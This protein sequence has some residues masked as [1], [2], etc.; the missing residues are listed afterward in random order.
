MTP[1]PEIIRKF[2]AVSSDYYTSSR[3]EMLPFIPQT[4]KRLLDLGCNKGAFGYLIKLL[5]GS[6]VWGID[7]DMGFG[8]IAEKQL[9]KVIIGDI[10]VVIHDI[11]DHYFDCISCNDVLEHLV[12]PYTVLNNLKSKLTSDG[13]IVC[14]IPNVRYWDNLKHLVLGKQWKYTDHGILD[15]THMRFFTELSIKDMF[16]SLNFD[17]VRMEGITPTR[18]R[19]LKLLNFLTRNSFEDARYLQFACVVKPKTSAQ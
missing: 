15:R 7:L 11:P 5:Y 4:T 12:D 2:N 3:K 17:I 16:K 10:N 9:D 1:T 19:N 14:S 18:S 6:E 13:V 8:A